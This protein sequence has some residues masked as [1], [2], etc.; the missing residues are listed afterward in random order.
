MDTQLE[1][2][3][4]TNT[5]T[6]SEELTYKA[7]KKIKSTDTSIKSLHKNLD[8]VENKL[9]SLQQQ[10]ETIVKYIKDQKEHKYR[11]QSLFAPYRWIPN[12]LIAKI[13]LNIIPEPNQNTLIYEWLIILDTLMNVCSHWRN[14]AIADP[15][16][17]KD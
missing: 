15:N 16:I 10:K 12:E 14:I 9:T 17:W 6:L 8:E 3:I 1:I 4:K 11:L 13:L 7:H 5:G 2:A